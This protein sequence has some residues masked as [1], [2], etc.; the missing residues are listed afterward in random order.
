MRIHDRSSLATALI[1]MTFTVAAC[2]WVRPESGTEGIALISEE[3]AEACERISSVEVSVLAR[4]AGM[5]RHQDAVESDLI[6]LARN[7]AVERGGDTIAALSEI[8]SGKQRY[9]V[10]RC[11][12]VDVEP[13]GDAV[14]DD[15][16]D[17]G[18]VVREYEG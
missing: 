9:G 4:V 2:T 17:E 16:D 15:D 1:A 7:H 18:V 14:E 12:D 13:N 11:R 3:Q 8:D 6:T 10:Y 5:D